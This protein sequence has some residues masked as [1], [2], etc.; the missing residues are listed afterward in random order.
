MNLLEGLH[1]QLARVRELRKF[2]DEIPSGSFGTQVIDA[3]IEQAESSIE[4]GDVVAMLDAFEELE[5]LE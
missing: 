4:S 5:A 2:Y 3:K 1:E